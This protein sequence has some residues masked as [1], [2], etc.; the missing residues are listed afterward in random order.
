MRLDARSFPQR[1]RD[2][3][4]HHGRRAW[5]NRSAEVAACTSRSVVNQDV[6]SSE[7]GLGNSAGPHNLASVSPLTG[8][9][10][11]SL[12]VSS[13]GGVRLLTGRATPPLPVPSTGGVRL[14]SLGFS[15]IIDDD[16]AR[17]AGPN[18]LRPPAG[19][20]PPR[21]AAVLTSLLLV[22][23]GHDV[24]DH[25]DLRV[26]GPGTPAPVRTVVPDPGC[27]RDRPLAPLVARSPRRRS[28][29]A[30]PRPVGR[31][32]PSDGDLSPP[33]SPRA[34]REPIP[35]SQGSSG[36]RAATH[37]VSRRTPPARAPHDADA[38]MPYGARD[39][40]K[41]HLSLRDAQTRHTGWEA[42]ERSQPASSKSAT[43]PALVILALPF[44]KRDPMSHLRDDRAGSSSPVTTREGDGGMVP[45]AWVYVL[46]STMAEPTQRTNHRLAAAPP[47]LV[48]GAMR[49]FGLLGRPRRAGTIMA[50]APPTVSTRST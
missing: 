11:P 9:A 32:A 49:A 42:H 22:S 4:E 34:S 38:A 47:R 1:P 19:N 15:T 3:S 17:G 48:V 45:D 46:P 43:Q 30:A 7:E 5:K 29:K 23:S 18:A 6:A 16:R 8:R 36:A 28:R 39:L 20:Q 31:T 44:C 27:S 21:V 37:T 10:T 12:P 40:A 2:L 33:A 50:R 35:D 24:P 26:E 41:S 14:V 13:T 25:R